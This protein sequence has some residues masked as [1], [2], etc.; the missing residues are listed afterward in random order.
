MANAKKKLRA[1]NLDM[2]VA[3]D[4]SREDA[5]FEADT[6]KV[7]MIYGDGNVEDLPLMAKDDVAN[8][9][10]DRVKTIWEDRVEHPGG[11]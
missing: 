7:K 5:G 8:L 11:A 1:K 10:L 3:N 4:V 6:N 9:V 2:I